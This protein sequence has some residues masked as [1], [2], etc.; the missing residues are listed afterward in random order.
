MKTAVIIP[1]AALLLAC[2][3]SAEV[4]GFIDTPPAAPTPCA[5][6]SAE[7]CNERDDD[8]DGAV[9]EDNACGD[10]CG[11][12]Q[13]SHD[14]A[15]RTDGTI[16]CWT[17]ADDG[18][19]TLRQVDDGQGPFVQIAGACARRS[20]GSLWCDDGSAS[21]VGARPTLPTTT[22]MERV[23]SLGFDVI[24]AAHHC[25][26]RS[27]GAVWCWG[28]PLAPGD[29]DGVPVP[30]PVALPEPAIRVGSD[31]AMACAVLASGRVSCWGYGGD[32]PSEPIV[33]PGL[34]RQDF[35]D[36]AVA[37]GH[38]CVR[39]AAGGVWCT[40]FNVYGQLCDGT[41]GDDPNFRRATALGDGVLALAV[42]D[43]DTCGMKADGAWCCGDGEPNPGG[44]PLA[45]RLDLRGV[46]LRTAG[47]PCAITTTGR[48]ICR[49]FFVPPVSPAPTT[50][51]EPVLFDLCGGAVAP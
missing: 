47:T 6:T 36:V 43:R 33:V 2:V 37:N 38:A 18:R 9:D 26:L 27:N 40:G 25:G 22:R 7:I 31:S 32:P 24:Q 45:R 51:L 16:W 50:E 35:D 29:V 10:P 23:K 21:D 14:C 41:I 19:V 12:A 28:A 8:C 34:T 48:V 1:S 30:A 3:R 15:L 49:R 13:L 44:R 17:I 11:A 4:G 42:E 20:D 46:T 5:P 39:S